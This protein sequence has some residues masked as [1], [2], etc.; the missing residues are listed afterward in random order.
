LIRHSPPLPPRPRQWPRLLW[1][2]VPYRERSQAAKR[3]GLMPVVQC[4]HTIDSLRPRPAKRVA[5]IRLSYRSVE[6]KAFID[7]IVWAST[8][9]FKF[10]TAVSGL[11]LWLSIW[12]PR[13]FEKHSHTT[14]SCRIS[15]KSRASLLVSAC[16]AGVR[17]HEG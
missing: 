6:N 13:R 7:F 10:T 16:K 11:L 4:L 2:E 3:S 5:A 17:G 12:N 15:P 1:V 14:T 9:G 8:S